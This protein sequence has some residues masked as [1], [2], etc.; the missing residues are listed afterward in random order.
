VRGERLVVYRL[1]V[2]FPNGSVLEQVNLSQS[3]ELVKRSE[4]AIFFDP[5]D[6]DLAIAG[7]DRLHAE[8]EPDI[9]RPTDH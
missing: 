2:E 4:L 3:D 8:L 9:V 1:R 7:L 6:I 5:E